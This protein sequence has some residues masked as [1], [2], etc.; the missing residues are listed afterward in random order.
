VSTSVASDASG[1]VAPADVA[2]ALK[3]MV[4]ALNVC[5][6]NITGRTFFDFGSGLGHVLA[7]AAALAAFDKVIGS[8]THALLS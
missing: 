3:K 6:V 1:I 8:L 4:G 2:R 5:G 7:A